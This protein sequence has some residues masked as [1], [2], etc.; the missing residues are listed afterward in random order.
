MIAVEAMNG[1]ASVSLGN[2]WAWV[3][4]VPVDTGAAGGGD[5]IAAVEAAATVTIG[6]FRFWHQ[7]QNEAR[8]GPSRQRLLGHALVGLDSLAS[9][10]SASGPA[11]EQSLGLFNDLIADA[12]PTPQV[13]VEEDGS[14]ETI[15]LVNG[16]EVIA[17][18]KPDGSGTL[19]ALD[20]TGE[21]FEFDFDGR[22]DPLDWVQ[23][24]QARRLL[25]RLG[26]SV[27]YRVLV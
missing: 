19:S 1:F 11:R 22:V 14:V 12:Q 26:E 8:F 27:D 21:L 17:F 10:S 15:W 18:V 13:A 4:R 5:A 23:I 9:G 2:S 16:T 3:P 25:N 6:A 20:A 7:A 24:T